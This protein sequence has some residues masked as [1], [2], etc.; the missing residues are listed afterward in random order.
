MN[1]AWTVETAA[2]K[3]LDV[4]LPLSARAPRFGILF[5]HGVGGETLRDQ[6][7]FTRVLDEL[8]LPCVSR[9]AGPCW[10]VDRPCPTFDAHITPERFVRETVLGYFKDRFGL[11]P[12][13]I[14]LLGISMG[15]QAA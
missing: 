14:G 5:L 15:G 3:S 1:G 6:P 13:S 9:S 11:L 7:A 2:G 4:Y 8:N 12:R 10:W